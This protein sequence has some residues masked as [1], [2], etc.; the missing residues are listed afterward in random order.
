MPVVRP[1][2][3]GGG[4]SGAEELMIPPIDHAMDRL[5]DLMQP[6]SSQSVLAIGAHPDDVEIGVGGILERH[7]RAGDRIMVLTCTG[8]ASGGESSR[9]VRLGVGSLPSRCF[10]RI[11]SRLFPG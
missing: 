6:V 2:I 5:D 11:S 4:H 10:S 8:G 1:E 3:L 7:R 9:R